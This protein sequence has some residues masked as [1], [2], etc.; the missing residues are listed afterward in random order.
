MDEENCK[1]GLLVRSASVREVIFLFKDLEPPSKDGIPEDLVLFWEVELIKD[2]VIF[3]DEVLTGHRPSPPGTSRSDSK[4]SVP[5]RLVPMESMPLKET[6]RLVDSPS[7][8]WALLW[9][10]S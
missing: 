8:P 6:T 9:T 10:S 2:E 5:G 7:G 1:D 3:R 4:T